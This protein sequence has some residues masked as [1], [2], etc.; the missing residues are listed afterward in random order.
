MSGCFA[1]LKASKTTSW[2]W[3]TIGQIES[4]ACLCINSQSAEHSAN[5]YMYQDFPSCPVVKTLP[6]SS[7]GALSRRAKIPPASWPKHQNRNN[8]VTKF[9]KYLKK[10]CVCSHAKSLQSCLTLWDSLDCS[11]SC[12]SV[13]RSYQEEYWSGLPI[14]PLGIFLTQGSNQV[15][16]SPLSH[17]ESPWKMLPL[18]LSKNSFFS[19]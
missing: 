7:G 5:G 6:S 12:S 11:L 19:L 15:D 8:I 1:C 13:Y 9:S 14:P 17:L 2:D 18:P 4:V 10:M 16:S 3:Q